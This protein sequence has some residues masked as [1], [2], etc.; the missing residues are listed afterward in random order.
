MW[1]KLRRD[2]ESL[3]QSEGKGREI[4]SQP[5]KGLNRRLSRSTIA[6]GLTNL[7]TLVALLSVI[8]TAPSK[9]E[10]AKLCTREL[11]TTSPA[12]EA[13]RYK[14]PDHYN[15]EFRQT[16]KWRGPPGTHSNEIDIA[17]HEIELGAGGIRVTE[18]EVKLLNMTDS[19]EMPFHKIPEEQGGGYLAM[20]EVF[21]LL[22]CLNS[23]RMGLFYNYDHY[24][25]L[26]E[27]VPDENIHSHFDHCI[28]MLRMNLQ[29]QADVTP[30][31][32]VDPLNNPLR[33]DALPN[34]SS[35]HTCRDFDAILD[36]NKHGPRSVRWRDAGANPSW[37][38]TLEG[39]EE[40]FPP[41]GVEEGHHH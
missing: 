26:D 24:K 41:E 15:A 22:H 9:D 37:D 13:V 25:F 16:N 17:W 11:S 19:P 33:R 32:F 20:L 28:D 2:Y 1:R 5:T 6:L 27:G 38:P 21:H 31:L 18:E 34:W 14:A 39:A 30:A 12:F 40:P 4:N 29:C 7:I 36:W 23:L 3:P 8:N 10:I 35:M